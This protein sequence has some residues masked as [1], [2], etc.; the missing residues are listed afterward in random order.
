MSADSTKGKSKVAP[1]CSE[2]QIVHERLDAMGQMA[3]GIVHDI[4]NTL[5][6]IVLYSEALAASESSLSEKGR[7]FLATIQQAAKD[8]EATT[9]RLRVFYRREDQAGQEAPIDVTHL[10]AEALER[11]RT[12]WK[13]VAFDA[14]SEV[15][16]SLGPLLGIEQ[17]I[18][19]ALDNLLHNAVEAMPEGGRLTI[20]ANKQAHWIA[21]Q[22]NDTGVG[23]S[24]EQQ[25]RCL[26]PF[27]STKDERAA[28]LGL[29][30]VYGV[31]Q[32]HA[33]KIEIESRAGQGTTV[34]LLFRARC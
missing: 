25:Q 26:E 5:V 33:G 18:Q 30:A 22:V 15:E 24:L 19:L 4:N 12:T 21:V 7:K 28:G 10:V 6:P 9:D 34:R 13:D 23:M 2:E 11:A 3:R 27:Y 29:A 31:M 8:I 14:A 16:D 17:E 20:T 1:R 32:R